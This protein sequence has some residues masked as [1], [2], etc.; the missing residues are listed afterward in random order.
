MDDGQ[1]LFEQDGHVGLLTLDR[2]AKLNAATR[3]MSEQL[4]ELIP[5]IDADPDVRAVVLTGAGKRAFSVGSD[6]SELDRYDGPWHF[7]NRRDYCDALRALRTP[8]IAAVNGYAFG[9]GLEL[10]LSCDIRLAAER[11]TFAAAEIK[12]GWIGGGGVTALLAASLAASDVAMMLL[13]G[14]PIDA[15]EALRIGLVSRVLPADELLPAATE[16]AHR[17]AARPPIAAQAAKAN[18]RAAQSMGLEPAI[19]YERELQAVA[20]GTQD[21]AEG[22]A[23]FAAKRTGSFEGR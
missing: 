19:Q 7:R 21:A 22:R 4:L 10:A 3:A 16:L 14:D 5:R 18:L 2:P 20:M 9:G 1:V 13:T 12:L 15:T 17:I 23:A 11:A 8:V 6:I